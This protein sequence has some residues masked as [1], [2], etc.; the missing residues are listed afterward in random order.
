MSTRNS[1]VRAVAI[2]VL[3]AAVTSGVL[4][5]VAKPPEMYDDPLWYRRSLTPLCQQGETA[6]GLAVDLPGMCRLS[7]GAVLRAAGLDELPY[8]E[9]DYSLSP[10]ANWERGAYAPIDAVLAMRGV[11]LAAFTGAILCLYAVAHRCLER[12]PLLALLPVAPF[13]LAPTF[14]DEIVP[15]VGPDALLTLWLAAFLLVWIWGEARGRALS[16]QWAVLLGLVGGIAAFAKQNGALVVLGYAAYAA[17]YTRGWKRAALPA[18]ALG[19]TFGVFYFSNPGLIGEWPHTVVADILSRRAV[20][21]SRLDTV[22]RGL[23]WT[24][25]LEYGVRYW[26][27]LPVLL[28]ALWRAR[29]APW[30]RPVYF[31]GG[32]L[33]LGTITMI[34]LP[35]PRYLGPLQLG[36]YFPAVLAVVWLALPPRPSRPSR[37]G[38]APA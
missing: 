2:L 31:W 32:A 37:A 13:V 22:Y 3:G 20:A 7:Y 5:A 18:L 23:T 19:V 34:N 16:W 27:L 4:A 25:S 11:N 8:R 30:S 26:S 33:F 10:G 14:I 36:L 17:A 1:V 35:L 9:V 21:A 28:F 15:H 12:R 24:E 6:Y 38:P 29:K